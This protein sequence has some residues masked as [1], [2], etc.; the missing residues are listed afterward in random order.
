VVEPDDEVREEAPVSIPID[1]TLD[2]HTFRPKD[3]GVL[4]PEYLAQCRKKGILRVRVIHGKGEGILLRTVHA[5]AGRLPEVESFSL[6]GP[7]EGGAGAT[8]VTLKPA[9]PSERDEGGT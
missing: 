1:G 7:L 2:L 5:L 6:A 8:I 9:G 3:V 4:V